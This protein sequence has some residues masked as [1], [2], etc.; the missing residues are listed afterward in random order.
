MSIGSEAVPEIEGPPLDRITSDDF[1]GSAV[2]ATK[3]LLWRPPNPGYLSLFGTKTNI[4]RH[5]WDRVYVY[6]DPL[7]YTSTDKELCLDFLP[8]SS[9]CNAFIPSIITAPASPINHPSIY[10]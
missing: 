9:S 7:E 5:F 4:R 6:G 3:C 1:T 2:I 8:R 10:G